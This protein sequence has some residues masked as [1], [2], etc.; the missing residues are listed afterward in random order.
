MKKG[1]FLLCILISSYAFAQETEDN[2]SGVDDRI[3]SSFVTVR[4]IYTIEK[5]K[6]RDWSF[7]IQKDITDVGTSYTLELEKKDPLGKWITRGWLSYS[8]IKEVKE[9]IEKH[10]NRPFPEDGAVK[11]E[12]FIHPNPTVIIKCVE[13]PKGKASAQNVKY[14]PKKRWYLKAGDTVV[15]EYYAI[16]GQ[17]I[18]TFLEFLQAVLNLMDQ[19]N[20]N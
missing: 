14:D 4:N 1:F 9:A 7:E 20:G 16:D 11:V 12:T 10:L 3:T 15:S 8:E 18:Q 2:E 5:P 17:G 6:I 19:L 13:N